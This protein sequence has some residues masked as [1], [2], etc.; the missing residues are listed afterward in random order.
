M[1]KKSIIFSI[2]LTVFF[3]FGC[4]SSTLEENSEIILQEEI[5][6][7]E[8]SEDIYKIMSFNVKYSH[9]FAENDWNKRK[10]VVAKHI[11]NSSPDIIGFQE[12]FSGNQSR[13][14]KS[15]VGEEYE[16]IFYSRISGIFGEGNP[17]YYRKDKFTLINRGM[18]W[19]NNNPDVM[20]A[21]P[22][23]NTPRICAYVE[24]LDNN[25]GKNI[26]YYNT[27]LP[28]EKEVDKAFAASVI[29]DQINSK[30]YGEDTLVMIGGDFNT[31]NDRDAYLKV[32]N[33]DFDD[34]SLLASDGDSGTTFRLRK[35]S[36]SNYALD[37]I[38]A[39]NYISVPFYRIFNHR[40]NEYY[41][42]DHYAIMVGVK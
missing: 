14:L 31:F 30:N 10:S 25:N 42:S 12:V 36:K 4:T 2:I 26:A 11:H 22:G 38:F 18:F 9:I 37:F 15:E 19:L 27:H 39:R 35:N 8:V 16:E 1:E 32:S 33:S 40:I 28:Y 7:P 17:I 34:L 41:A 20:A 5:D 23:T 13:S 6:I 3:L 29:I 21:L 24:L